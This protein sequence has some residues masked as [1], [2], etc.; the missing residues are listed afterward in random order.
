[1][2]LGLARQL[3]RDQLGTLQGAMTGYGD[4]VHLAAGPPGRRARFYLVTHPDGVQQVL[5]GGAEGYSKDTLFYREIAASF[6]DGLLTSN[7]QRWR[8][9][10]RTLAPLFT[11]RR[12]ARYVAVMADEAARLRHRW[13]A[14]ATSTRVDLHAEMVEYTLRVVGRALFGAGMDDAIPTI[15]ATFPVVSEAARRRATAAIPLPPAWPTPARRRAAS[16]MRALHAVV[17]AI[18]ERRRDA[19]G[20]AEDLVSLLLAAR[21]PETGAPL[22]PREVRDQVLIFLLAGHETT[23]TT[24]TFALHLLGRHPDVQRRVHQELDDVL[25]ARA[26]T[27]EDL[28]RLTYTTM[29]VKEAMRLY[30]PAYAFG[31]RSTTGDR[32]GGHR[33]PPG[34]IVVVSPWATHRHPAYW[35]D[36]ERF[37]PER[38][39]PAAA[40]AR[41]RYA[42]FPFGGGPR[43]CI[44]SHFGLAEAVVAVAVLLTGRELRADPAPVPLSTAITLRPAGPVRCEVVPRRP[45]APATTARAAEPQPYPA[46]GGPA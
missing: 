28:G 21:D 3:R 25:A 6:G 20:D 36:P 17:D 5:A 4:V 35:P 10:R 46:S 9:Q 37:D 38:F 29:V 45:T 39:H 14:A 22:S 40:S 2:L 44:G 41:H 30:P 26:P 11:P 1:L 33:I 8:Q 19:P 12:V 23:A 42:W 27:A 7:G 15:R 16:A 43:A 13:T 24:L 31:R 34:S 32:I 18:V